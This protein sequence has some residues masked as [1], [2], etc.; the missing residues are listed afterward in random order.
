MAAGA[1]QPLQRDMNRIRTHSFVSLG[2]SYNSSSKSFCR[3]CLPVEDYG[4]FVLHAACSTNR[5]SLAL[6]GPVK[7]IKE[8]CR[9]HLKENSS[10][11]RFSQQVLHFFVF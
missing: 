9:T 8:K 4:L 7:K 2:E 3:F 1:L 10:F 11:S 5:P 6:K